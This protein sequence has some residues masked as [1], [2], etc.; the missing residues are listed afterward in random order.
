[1]M[2]IHF[3][4]LIIDNFMSFGHAELDFE[5]KGFT[6]VNGINQNPDDSATSNGSGKSSL[7]NALSYVLTGETI[8]GLSNNLNN[9]YIDDTMSVYVNFNVDSICYEITRSRDQK[10][11]TTLKIIVNG[12][13]KSGKGIRESETILAQYLPDLTSEILGEVIIIGQGMPHKFSS[14]T[15]SGRK[16][17]L[18]KLSKSDFMIDDIKTRVDNRS[19]ILREQKYNFD[20][21]AASLNTN[22]DI[23]KKNLEQ[24]NEDYNIN[25]K[26]KPDFDA[27]IESYNNKIF[28]LEKLNEQSSTIKN[29]LQEE[30]NL[31][32]DK[33]SQLTD[34]KDKELEHEKENF[35]ASNKLVVDRIL[36]LRLSI[37]ELQNTITRLN[38]ITDICPT[39]KQKIPDI[40]KPD[41]TNEENKLSTLKAE[42]VEVEKE[43]NIQRDSYRIN[44]NSIN[45]SYML[46][47]TSIQTSIND[48]SK[49]INSINDELNSYNTQISDFKI[50]LNKAILKKDIFEENRIKIETQIADYKLQLNNLNNE[51]LYIIEKQEELKAHLDIISKITTLIKRDFRGILLDNVIK[52]LDDK[53]KS[54]CT[55]IFNTD[56]LSFKL[57]GNDISI[58][59]LDKPLEA[60]SG[61][62]QQKVNFIIQLAIRSMMQDT[63][64]FTSNILVLDEILDNLDKTGC[65]QIIDFISNNLTDIESIFIISHHA[66]SLNI[67][68]DSSITIIKNEKGISSIL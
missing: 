46:S 52:Y 29:S 47:K 59:Y 20:L 36:N 14:Y 6:L 37:N 27:D 12:E 38:S 1:M 4:K 25:Y 26:D 51:L 28:E 7:F 5:D 23:I 45:D 68:N 61:G 30:L 66:E 11:K 67:C 42:L 15:P 65:D 54:Y 56:A 19:N 39:C 21:K 8:Q 55:K 57:D 49:A 33:L 13:D 40:I 41:T 60:L 44:C 9:K 64:G 22:I 53:C 16:D 35:D 2:Q 24:L 10:N 48:K 58:T 17:L 43:D 63:I 34:S 32:T 31:L 18:E 62:E 3:N 50:L